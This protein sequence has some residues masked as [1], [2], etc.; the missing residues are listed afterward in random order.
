MEHEEA[1]RVEEAKTDNLLDGKGDAD[2]DTSGNAEKPR[3]DNALGP[4]SSQD[5][6]EET[7]KKA[8]Q[9]AG[10]NMEDSMIA[11]YIALLL[12]CIIQDNRDNANKIRDHLPDKDFN[13]MVQ[14]LK[15]F[16]NFMNL[17]NI[18]GSTGMKSIQRV[19][20]ILEA[21]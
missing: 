5:D 12:G 13:I 4:Q 21:T 1:A 6:I 15:K 14:I 11:A 10:K 19:I 8:L 20:D 16:L 18:V 7:L 9:K 2:D 17:T 3:E